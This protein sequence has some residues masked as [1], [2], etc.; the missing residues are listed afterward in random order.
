MGLDVNTPKGQIAVIDEARAIGIFLDCNDGYRFVH[1]PK[2]KASKVDGL[3]LK[4]DQLVA[5]IETKCRYD[6]DLE[7][8][9]GDYKSQWLVTLDKVDSARAMAHQL[10][11]PLV[12]FLYVEKDRTLLVQRITDEDGLLCVQMTSEATR[13]QETTN[14]GSV[15][16]NNAY[17]DMSRAKVYQ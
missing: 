17:I 11:V 14:G 12:G 13:T 8:F 2:T 6:F 3:L 15:V 1:T 16:R 5:V 7:K 10:N 4:G 9:R